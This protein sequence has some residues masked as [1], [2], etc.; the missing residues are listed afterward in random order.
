[1]HEWF[2]TNGKLMDA[3]GLLD[4]DA[5]GL[6]DFMELACLVFLLCSVINKSY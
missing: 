5:L 6:L 1:M 3:L 2:I 4:F